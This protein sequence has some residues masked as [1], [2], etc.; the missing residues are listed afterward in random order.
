M[1]MILGAVLFVQRLDGLIF[2][3]SNNKI[4][5]ELPLNIGHTCKCLKKFSLA[6]DEFVGSI[7]TSFT[8]MVSLLKLNLS[9]NRLRGH[10]YLRDE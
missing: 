7:P 1:V 6:S 3:A 8:D 5:G 4:V 9:G 10:I 2:D